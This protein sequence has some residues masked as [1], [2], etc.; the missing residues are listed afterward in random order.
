MTSV[1]KYWD[2]P[3]LETFDASI[4]GTG[5]L[6]GKPT[7]VLGETIFYPEGGGQLGDTGTL[8]IGAEVVHVI[9]TQIDDAGVIH[10][11]LERAIPAR[12]GERATC[13]IDVAR[14]RDHMAQHT[15][16]H[17]LSRALLDE[18]NAPTVSARLG[19]T[20]CTLD[21]DR[22]AIDDAALHRA[23]DL[24]ND[25]IRS[26][27]SV[28]A[29]FP[30]PGELA[31]MD[32]RRAPK[33]SAGVRI[34]D[35]DGFDLTPCGGTHVT[36]TGQIGVMRIAQLE[37]Y[38][39]KL[40]VSFHA[41]TRALADARTKENVLSSLA[42]KFTCGALDVGAAVGK[43]QNDLKDRTDAL[44]RARGELFELLAKSILADTPP[45]PDG[46]TLVRVARTDGD[47]AM[48]RTLVGKLA[49]ARADVVAICTAPDGDGVL[50]V[51]QRGA[52]ASFDCG[53]WLKELAARTGGRG[54]GRP[55][56]AEGRVPKDAPV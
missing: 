50:V 17:M 10:H 16:Q 53:A 34:I 30:T 55:E 35:V 12:E 14:R 21:V 56:R 1:K 13:A 19:K 22:A 38:K 45:S 37:R 7:L 39:G 26:D 41:A 4:V 24:V 44:A 33:V 3:F 48:L 29:L 27:V 11:V 25:V 23:E 49:S 9:D 6:E 54:G 15:A 28:R 2:D 43:L 32:L 5:E 51:V 20:T 46:T 47:V 42:E 8:R 40:R 52:S 31:K 36:R 18:A